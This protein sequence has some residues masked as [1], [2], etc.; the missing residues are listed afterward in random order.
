MGTETY[1]IFN[2]V[3][4]GGRS[5]KLKDRIIDEI[6]RRFSRN[7][8]LM[9][10]TRQGDAT[11]FASKAARSG[12]KLIIIIGGDG[13][14]NEAVNGLLVKRKA[15]SDQ[16]EIGILNCGSG[17]G[18]AQT[19]GLPCRFDDQLDMILHTSS[20]PMD[21][22]FVSFRDKNDQPSEHLFV[23]ECQVGIGGSV[24]SCV[25]IK[26]KHFGGKIAFGLVALSHLF[27]YKAS[28]MVMIPDHRA[29]EFNK[30][31]GITI[32]N[33]IHCAGGMTLTP[34]AL[35]D[36]GLLDVLQIHDMNLPKRIRNF[37]KVYSG[38]HIGSKYFSLTK[39]KELLID[40]DRPVWI[41]TDGELLGY[42]PCNVGIIPGGIKVR[43][44]G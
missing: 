8:F 18:V 11:F 41:E 1:I 17:C 42:T 14:I 30:L 27:H 4:G 21:V 37:G 38:N 29:A 43:Y 6:E 19:L 23:S 7:Y 33:G 24:V 28:R 31:I 34:S 22:G 44:G 26:L 3:A 20:K 13:T 5:G 12:A 25:G 16:C 36:D 40:S 39:V 9:E 32:G 10:T 2:P 15:I 35:I